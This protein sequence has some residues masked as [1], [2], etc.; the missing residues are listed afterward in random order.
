MEAEIVPYS[1]SH[2]E[3]LLGQFLIRSPSPDVLA[4][5]TIPHYYFQMAFSVAH[6][7]D[8]RMEFV[9]LVY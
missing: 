1:V 3:Q 8:D 2:L 9:V 5:A 4:A 7:S 6:G